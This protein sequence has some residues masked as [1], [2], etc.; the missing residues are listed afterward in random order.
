VFLDVRGEVKT[1]LLGF[2]VAVSMSANCAPTTPQTENETAPVT[3]STTRAS[4]MDLVSSFEAGG[5]VRARATALVASRVMAPITA[6]HVRPGD[7]V[8][9]G[10]T[11]VTLDA[12][13]VQANTERAGAT[14]RSAIEAA[15]AADAD[16]RAAQSGLVLARATHDRIA[17]LHAKRSATA[18]ELDQAAAALAAAEAQR[19]S[20]QARLAASNAAREAAQASAE[21]ATIGA[22][23]A[24]LSAPFDGVVTERHADPGSMATPGIP[25]LTLDDPAVYRLEIQLDEAR[26]AGVA[27]DEE[28][29]VRIDNTPGGGE[30]WTGGRVAEIARVDAASHRFL[31]KIDLPV[32]AA[33][34]SGLFGRARF[35]GA[36]RQALT[37]PGAALIRRGQLTFVYVVDP[38]NRAR[39][40]P[41]STAASDQ[42]PVE[43]LAGLRQGDLVVTNPPAALSDGARVAG[44]Q[45]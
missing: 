1:T 29:A 18:Q 20:A 4:L 14:A 19:A 24:V 32:A 11:L 28:V 39:L 7:R 23:Y 36:T 27:T 42:D 34:R 3:V 38:E 13:D 8:R 16:V 10:A 5:V 25:I 31:V 15:R 22:T 30:G 44:G 40:R 43:V 12:R 41:I 6:I 35:S 2:V 26:A 45:P 33:V 37:V 17:A 21:A 9:R